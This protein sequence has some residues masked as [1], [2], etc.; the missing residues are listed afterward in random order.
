MAL[1][2][3]A[4]LFGV[5]A[6]IQII[7]RPYIS[8]VRPII[9]SIFI[10]LILGIYS[11]TKVNQDSESVTFLTSYISIFIIGLLFTAL[12]FNIICIIAHKVGKYREKKNKQL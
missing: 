6:I 3:A 7:I 1:F 5:F 8:N 10:T 11:Y 4:G 2:G 9:N 12:L